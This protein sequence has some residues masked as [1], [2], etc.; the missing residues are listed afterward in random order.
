MQTLNEIR[1]LLESHGLSPRHALGQNF[2]IDHNLIRKL[3]DASGVGA[4]DVV[5]EV[6]PGTG[7]M[8]EELV[9]RGC[10]VIA[11]ELDAGLGDLLTKTL[12]ER[13]TLVRGDCLAGKSAMN[14]EVV[15]AL[16][17]RAFTLVSNLPYGAASPLMVTILTK[18][19]ECRG[20]FVTIQKEVGE[21]LRAK[22]GTKDY[23]ELGVIAQALAE[24]ER[25][26]VLPGAC[27]WPR[28]KVE[29]EMVSLVRRDVALTRDA[30][31]LAR[32]CRVLFTKRRKQ[33]GAILGR[34]FGFPDGIDA[35]AR[36]ESLTVEQI[37]TLA[38]RAPIPE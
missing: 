20:M 37:E 5:L 2:L 31:A 4:G 7:T 18:H 24:I 10:E 29:S 33:I 19:P 13:I 12:G 21:R 32:M 25:I 23:G 15:A 9:A 30:E 36:P 38:H 6:G 35:S 22:P 28:P 11:C 17:G 26:A 34:G 16:R 3:V 27:F 14:E 1:F 8:T